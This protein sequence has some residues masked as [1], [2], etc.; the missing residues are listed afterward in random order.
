MLT[1]EAWQTNT[2][3]T[4]FGNIIHSKQEEHWVNTQRKI[5]VKYPY[6]PCID[7]LLYGCVLLQNH[8]YVSWKISYMYTPLL[9]C[10]FWSELSQNRHRKGLYVPTHFPISWALKVR[11]IKHLLGFP[12]WKEKQLQRPTILD[13]QYLTYY[14]AI[15]L[16]WSLCVVNVQEQ[17]SFSSRWFRS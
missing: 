12:L 17:K 10:K 2:L 13:L 8:R 1:E 5:P 3:S 11:K 7:C 14:I 15:Y 9:C 16:L 6:S 4:I